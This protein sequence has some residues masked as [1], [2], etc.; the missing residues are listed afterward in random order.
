DEHL[1]RVAATMNVLA[2]SNSRLSDAQ[3]RLSDAQ[4][5]TEER[6]GRL[7]EAIVRGFTDATERHAEIVERLDRLERR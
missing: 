2:A 5:L 3:A 4:A 6:F 1:D 7:S